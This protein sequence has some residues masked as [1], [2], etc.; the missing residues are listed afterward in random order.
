MQKNLIKTLSLIVGIFILSLYLVPTLKVF[1]VTTGAGSDKAV[2]VLDDKAE[3]LSAKASEEVKKAGAALVSSY[4]EMSF[5]VLTTND[6]EGKAS[7]QYGDDT[8]TNMDIGYGSDFNIVYLLINMEIREVHVG[9]FGHAIDVFT[10][11]RREAILDTVYDS[12]KNADYD[13]AVLKTMAEFDFYMAQGVPAGQ[14]REEYKEPITPGKILA[15]IAAFFGSSSLIGVTASK[16]YQSKIRSEYDSVTARPMY[17]LRKSAGVA[18]HAIHDTIT[19]QSTNRIYSPISS[20]SGSRGLSSSGG[21]SRSTT[22]SSSG[23]RSSSGS[24]R[25]F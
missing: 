8:V 9:S 6:A 19:N 18:Y 14:Y 5:A 17:D 12:L 21:S 10:D 2:F 4:P 15:S 13:E 24:S 25:R 22:R 23:G 16:S 7:W 3:L 11:D 1:A 20:S